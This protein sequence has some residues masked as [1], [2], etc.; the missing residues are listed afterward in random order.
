MAKKKLSE[1]QLKEIE[2]LKAQREMYDRTIEETKLRGNEKAVNRLEIA[3]QDTIEQLRKIDPKLAVKEPKE[4]NT[5]ISMIMNHQED[6]RPMNERLQSMQ[7]ENETIKVVDTEYEP[8]TERFSN[9]DTVTNMEFNTDD[10]DIAFDIIS[11][12]SNGECYS[13]KTARLQVG[14]L[15]SADENVITSPQLYK[16]GAVID[17]LL[18]RKVLNKGFDV[19]NLCRGDVEA[20]T[21]FLRATS[22]GTDFPVYVR[23]P[24]SGEQIEANVD[25]R[26]LKSKPFNLKG[27]ENGHFEFVLPKSKDVIKFKFMTR[28]DEKNLELLA[29]LENNSSKAALLKSNIELIKDVVKADINLNGKEKQEY[30]NNLEK[31]MPWVRKTEKQPNSAYNHLITNRLE[32]SVMAVNG[33]YDRKFISKY[34][35]NMAAMDSLMLRRY[36]NDNEPGIDFEV[37]IQRPESLGGGSFKTF[38]EWGDSVFLNFN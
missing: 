11:L 7:Q 28:K 37:E 13:T 36:I 24:E 19:D 8:I 3:K 29:T 4:E 5:V 15:T 32:M 21:V 23:D 31:L 12:P 20:I 10:A 30:I 26:T 18:H 27:D 16:D 25:L 17:L 22:Y 14:F 35:R 33:N 2:Y 34:V 1:E 38:L 6:E 9:S